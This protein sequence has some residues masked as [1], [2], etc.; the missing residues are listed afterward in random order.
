MRTK[1]K[2]CWTLSVSP[3]MSSPMLL[4]HIIADILFASGKDELERSPGKERKRL[5]GRY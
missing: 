5:A 3:L 1:V 4:F 2:D